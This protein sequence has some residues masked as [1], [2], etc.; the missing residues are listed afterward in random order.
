MHDWRDCASS[1][2]KAV[3]GAEVRWLGRRSF[4]GPRIDDGVLFERRDSSLT[5]TIS[6]RTFPKDALRDLARGYAL[7]TP[8]LRRAR[9]GHLD[10]EEVATRAE[11]DASTR[12]IQERNDETG[13]RL[14]VCPVYRHKF[15]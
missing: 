14:E 12:L 9:E 2:L 11:D 7:H 5:T 3:I 8:S 10:V 15:V 6:R 13:L 1:G 4:G